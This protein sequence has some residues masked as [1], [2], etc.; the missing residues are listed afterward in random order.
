MLFPLESVQVSGGYV[1]HEVIAS[2]V[3]KAGDE[4]LL[5]VDEVTSP[6][7]VV[8][9]QIGLLNRPCWIEWE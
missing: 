1:I 9:L 2:E 5:F 7:G 3:L 4:V 6:Y 8:H